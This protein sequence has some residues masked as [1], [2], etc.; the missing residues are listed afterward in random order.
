M[1]MRYLIVIYTYNTYKK[2]YKFRSLILKS[3]LNL[4]QIGNIQLDWLN[5]HMLT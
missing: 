4:V 1:I 5:V 3:L 2:V